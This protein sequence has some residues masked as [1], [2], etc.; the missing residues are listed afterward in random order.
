MINKKSSFDIPVVLFLFKRIDKPL[1]VLKRISEVKPKRLYLLSDGGRNDEEK[2]QVELCRKEIEQAIDWDCEVIKRYASENIGVY[3]NIAGGAKWVFDREKYAIF[4]EDDNLPDISFFR[5]CEELLVKYKKDTRVLW[6][7]GTNYLGD[8]LPKNKASYI[9]TRNMQPCGWA[10]WSDKFK[11]FYDGNLNLLENELVRTSLSKTYLTKSLYKQDCMNWDD[12]KQRILKRGKPSSWDYQMSLSI[13]AHNLFGI[14]P[15]SN[16]IKNI[17]VDEDSIHGGVSMDL[18][19][20]RRFCEIPLKEIDFPLI[21]PESL[22]IDIDF[23]RKIEKIITYPL[24]MRLKRMASVAIKKFL[25]VDTDR[26]IKS[27]IRI[28]KSK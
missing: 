13:R 9:F 17:G 5:Y 28:K 18:E 7:C 4:L 2:I 3:E 1:L 26:S 25:N 15:K 24:Y 27:I 12:E 10:S 14:V 6:I 21:H 22:T 16:L 23:E 20:T 19:M 11:R 8:Y